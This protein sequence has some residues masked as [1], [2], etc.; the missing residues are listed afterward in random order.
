FGMTVSCV[1]LPRFMSEHDVP[2]TDVRTRAS[3]SFFIRTPCVYLRDHRQCPCTA[4][5][6]KE[7]S[8]VWSATRDTP[9]LYN[10]REPAPQG[11]ARKRGIRGLT[12]GIARYAG[13]TP[14]YLPCTAP[15]C[16]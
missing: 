16:I 2:K 3:T 13:S 8:Q 12:R 5:R 6:C 14:G 4:E 15:R 1:E 7:L 9:G 10:Q 11:G